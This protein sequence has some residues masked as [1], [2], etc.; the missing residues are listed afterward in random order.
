[1]KALSHNF[2]SLYP[3]PLRIVIAG[4]Q[5]EAQEKP[6][7]SPN[8]ILEELNAYIPDDYARRL[9][10]AA[11]C[12][13]LP[14]IGSNEYS[15][16]TF[17]LACASGKYVIAPDRG[18]LGWRIRHYGN[19]FLFS[20]DNPRSLAITIRTFLKMQHELPNPCPGSLRYGDSCT[21]ER[22]V[23][24]LDRIIRVSIGTE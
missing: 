23:T 11:D 16:G 15:S 4:L 1:M 18:I 20:P 22:Y 6:P 10:G 2:S 12:I 17:S 24:I 19:G 14:F 5:T 7:L 8:V 21:P 3:S 13:I 9:I